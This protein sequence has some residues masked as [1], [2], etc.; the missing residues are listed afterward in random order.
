MEGIIDLDP[1]SQHDKKRV[2]ERLKEHENED[3][4]DFNRDRIGEMT[5]DEFDKLIEE[6]KTRVEMDRTK[7]LQSKKIATI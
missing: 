6:R 4:F 3:E 7:E 2:K 1:F 5:L